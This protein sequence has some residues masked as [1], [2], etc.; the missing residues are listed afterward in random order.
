MKSLKYIIGF[1]IVTL[2]F[3]SPINS[4]FAAQSQQT[5]QIS[6]DNTNIKL[7]QWHG[8]N[9]DGWRFHRGWYRHHRRWRCWK[10]WYRRHHR[11]HYYWVCRRRW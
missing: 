5:Q 2:V 4:A 6:A 8:R 9:W 3:I 10:H 11:W 1:F 7:A